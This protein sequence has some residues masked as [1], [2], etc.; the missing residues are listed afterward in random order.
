MTATKLHIF[1]NSLF[2]IK[3]NENMYY[4]P[5]HICRRIQTFER[6]SIWLKP[7][8]SFQIVFETF[9]TFENGSTNQARN[10]YLIGHLTSYLLR[11]ERKKWL[12]LPIPIAQPSP[13]MIIHEQKNG[14]LKNSA[15]E[16]TLSRQTENEKIC[17]ILVAICPPS[18]FQRVKINAKTTKKRRQSERKSKEITWRWD[19]S[20]PAPPVNLYR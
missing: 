9:T 18:S 8:N 7:I 3:A 15:S 19:G 1:R 5:S 6:H 14:I 16:K 4:S 2:K 17:W 13:K 12:P 20:P 11:E 10:K